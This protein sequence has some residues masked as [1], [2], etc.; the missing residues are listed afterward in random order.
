M[1]GTKEFTQ[2]LHNLDSFLIILIIILSPGA[3]NE[4][5]TE[6]FCDLV[7]LLGYDAMTADA[8]VPKVSPSPR[9]KSYK[10]S[11]GPVA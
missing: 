10:S 5:P 4:H 8:L 2:N 9:S 6:I 11:K 3:L 1:V 7:R